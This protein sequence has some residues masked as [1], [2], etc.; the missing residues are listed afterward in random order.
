MMASSRELLISREELM[1]LRGLVIIECVVL[2][3]LL[4]LLHYHHE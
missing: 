4:P 2:L 1:N 3:L